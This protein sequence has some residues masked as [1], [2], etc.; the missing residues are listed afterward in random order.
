VGLKVIAL[1][2][3]WMALPPYQISW[4]STKRFK[5]Y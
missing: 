5:S 2:F 4:K 3:P 1:S